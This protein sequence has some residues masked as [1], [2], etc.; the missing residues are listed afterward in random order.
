MVPLTGYRPITG[1]RPVT[2]SDGV[3]RPMTAVRGAGY[4]SQNK[5]FDPLN[6]GALSAT[7]PLELPKD[8]S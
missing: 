2:G 3:N 4:S 1:F 6:Q 8:E 7:P 5:V